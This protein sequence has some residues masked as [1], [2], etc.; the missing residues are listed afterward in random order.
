[1]ETTSDINPH[2]VNN[3]N[4]NT[5][6]ELT[7]VQHLQKNYFE[8]TLRSSRN[9]HTGEWTHAKIFSLLQHCNLIDKITGLDLKQENT[10]D[11]NT[12]PTYKHFEISFLDQDS[13]LKFLYSGYVH[14]NRTLFPYPKED[15]PKVNE[16]TETN[17]YYINITNVPLEAN[18]DDVQQLILKL[19]ENLPINYQ[20]TNLRNV[21]HTFTDTA[22]QV[23]TGRWEV[24]MTTNEPL[25]PKK[26]ETHRI[27]NKSDY[28]V[29]RQVQIHVLKKTYEETQQDIKDGKNK[30]KKFITFTIPQIEPE[31]QKHN[32]IQAIKNA[33][34]DHASHKFVTQRDIR[35]NIEP[36]HLINKNQAHITMDK[37]LQPKIFLPK[38]INSLNAIKPTFGKMAYTLDEGEH[39]T[40][41]NIQARARHKE[42]NATDEQ[43]YINIQNTTHIDS[44][45]DIT[46]PTITPQNESQQISDASSTPTVTSQQISFMSGDSGIKYNNPFDTNPILQ[47]TLHSST[48]FPQ[49]H[50][51]TPT[52]GEGEGRG[53]GS[54]LRTN[55]ATSPSLAN[56]QTTDYLYATD[57]SRESITKSKS[58][59]QKPLPDIDQQSY[60]DVLNK[61]ST[62]QPEPTE[63]PLQVLTPNMKTLKKRSKE[64][65]YSD[66][67]EETDKK[68]HRLSKEELQTKVD[69]VTNLQIKPENTEQYIEILAATIIKHKGKEKIYPDDGNVYMITQGKAAILRQIYGKLIEDNE[70]QFKE[71]PKDLKRMWKKMNNKDKPNDKNEQNRFINDI[72][73]TLNIA[74]NRKHK[75]S[76]TPVTVISETQ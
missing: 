14:R 44:T 53:G 59:L 63:S 34:D 6:V 7:D 58:L 4:T 54:E 2:T 61:I 37:R 69:E 22:I 52:H 18:E 73:T 42:T 1:M 12:E 35:I 76:G 71:L 36:M 28:F 47:D 23:K 31:T 43:Q 25:K 62:N 20:L 3:E 56:T 67:E 24:K 9:D 46:S 41:N 39:L 10:H 51:P 68:K 29:V 11:E 48:P 13:Y 38:L 16:E 64:T 66:I 27:T 40:Y 32:I 60:R 21:K 8:L 49:T 70:E 72:I 55:D 15:E 50:T 33:I 30:Y 5:D 65:T 75:I 26:H 74:Y 45:Q 19:L 57:K 17:T